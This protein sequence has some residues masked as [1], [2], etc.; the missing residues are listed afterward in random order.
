MEY[1]SPSLAKIAMNAAIV[2]FGKMGILHAGILNSLEGVRLVA[3][4]EKEDIINNYVQKA[5]PQVNFYSNYEKMLSEETLDL[6][7]VTTPVSSHIPIANSCIEHNANFFIEKPLAHGVNECRELCHKLKKTSLVHA[8]GY[9]KRF[10]ETFAKAK[11]LLNSGTLGDFIYFKSSMYVSQLFTKGKGWRYKKHESGG[12]VL[13]EFA[14]HLIDLLL[15]Y[16]GP[17]ES[18]SAITRSYYSE[19]VEDFAHSTMEFETGL[20]GHLDT[21]WSVRNYRLPEITI[22]VHGS[23]GMMTVNDDSIRISLDPTNGSPYPSLKTIYKQALSNGTVIDIGGPEYTKE[24]LHMVDCVKQGN[25]TNISCFQA[26]MV[27]SVI[28]AMYASATERVFKK[29]E[30]VI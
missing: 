8:V 19:D 9:S 28:D 22:E 2:G 11:E 16:F 27:Q 7:Y 21:S 24:D 14:S 26:S 3:V 23:K 10:L 6:V 1:H 13:L 15:W 12:G 4:A 17:I 25:Q 30:Y 18:V 20:K 29:V 5:L